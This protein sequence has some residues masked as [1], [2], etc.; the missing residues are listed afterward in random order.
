STGGN[1]TFYDNAAGSPHVVIL[2]G[3]GVAPTAALVADH[4]PINFGSVAAGTTSPPLTV[5]MTN[6]GPNPVTILNVATSYPLG[7]ILPNP[8]Q[9]SSTTC[10]NVTL[11]VNQTCAVA[12]TWSPAQ[13]TAGLPST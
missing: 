6:H 10:V 3:S 8:F 5:I 7:F 12:V 4:N 2:S 9:V 1:L 13:G 11:Q